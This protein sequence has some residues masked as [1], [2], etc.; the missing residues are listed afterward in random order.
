M[1]WNDLSTPEG[2]LSGTVFSLLTPILVTVAAIAFG[3]RAVA[4]G[5][6]GGALELVPALRARPEPLVNGVDAGYTAVLV[7]VPLVLVAIGTVWFA[8]RDVLVQR[9]VQPG[10]GADRPPAQ[11]AYP[12]MPKLRCRPRGGGGALTPP[13]RVARR[14]TPRGR[15]APGRRG[16]RPDR[17]A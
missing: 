14:R 3:T 17:R 8:R 11:A 13:I 9:A 6:G 2:Y 7:A 15:K 12:R 1:G 10:A 4:G 5:E 16:P